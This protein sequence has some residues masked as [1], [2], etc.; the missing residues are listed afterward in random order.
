M[1]EQEKL[2]ECMDV[3]KYFPVYGGFPRREVNS[4]KAVDGVSLDIR[5]GETLGL[6]GE[7]GCGK[8]TMARLI[9]R[10]LEPTSGQM[11]FQGYDINTMEGKKLSEFRRSVQIVF[12]DPYASL[13]PRIKIGDVIAEMLDAHDI[14][15]RKEQRQRTVDLL[16]LVGLRS[17]YYD[18]YPHEF[19]GGERQRIGIAR[20]LSLNPK[21]IVC[22]EPVSSL[23]VSIQAQI[24]NLLR[25]LQNGLKLTLV[26]ITHD[27]AVVRYISDRV[28][29]MYLGKIVE[30]GDT[31][32]LI[33]NPLHP[34]T[35]G[36][37]ASV[38]TP[39]PN[40]RR[41]TLLFEGDVPNPINPP[42]G[43]RFHTRCP[44]V[45]DRCKA[46]EPLLVSARANRLVACHKVQ[47]V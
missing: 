9:V 29:V 16:E 40:V 22:D 18:R 38:P 13:N 37:V 19:S 27:L 2:F 23:D 39:D 3:R 35:K 34:Y 4:V 14:C 15:P 1:S 36:L 7:S 25:N 28:A 43:C 46:E 41:E 21:L 42:Q 11:L 6:V 20:A 8:T 44:F 47:S 10:L 45:L 26:F 5:L 32:A 17:S 12:Q 30:V 24:L 31:G 33:D